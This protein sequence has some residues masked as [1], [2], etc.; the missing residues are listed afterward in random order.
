V[1]QQSLAK[2]DEAKQEELLAAYAQFLNALTFPFQLLVRVTPIDLAWYVVRVEER[3]RVLSSGLVAIARDHAA[4]VQSLAR[5]RTLLE[6]RIYVALPW[7]GA[8]SPG[9]SGS[10]DAPAVLRRLLALL[11]IGRG[12]RTDRDEVFTEESIA[13]RLADRCDEVSRQLGRAG[14]RT[15]RLDDLALAQLFHASWAPELARTQRL[16]RELTEYTALVVQ[17]DA[18]VRRGHRFE[19][20]GAASLEDPRPRPPRRV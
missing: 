17:A 20:D 4:F 3:A 14:L 1:S 6:R 2:V 11:R 9:L 5:Q 7:S 12:K 15:T 16:R 19:Q 18:T 8:E 13:R 10:A